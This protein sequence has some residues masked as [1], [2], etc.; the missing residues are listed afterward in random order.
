MTMHAA[1]ENLADQKQFNSTLTPATSSFQHLLICSADAFGEHMKLTS[2]KLYTTVDVKR[3]KEFWFVT[4]RSS[5]R[6]S[7]VW[8]E[9]KIASEYQTSMRKRST[10]WLTKATP[11]SNASSNQQY[12]LKYCHIL[13]SKYLE[14][15]SL[16]SVTDV[17]RKVFEHTHTQSRIHCSLP[18][19]DE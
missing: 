2:V 12:V 5:M 1:C 8:N 15:F 7:F 10:G 14:L 9:C 18:G 19:D 13:A 16:L 17:I 6:N 11:S 3:L 4:M